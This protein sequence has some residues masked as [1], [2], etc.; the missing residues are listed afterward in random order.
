M[1]VDDIVI[2]W[3]VLIGMNL[4]ESVVSISKMFSVWSWS[5]A[6]KQTK[7]NTEKTHH[8]KRIVRFKYNAHKQHQNYSC[9]V[10]NCNYNII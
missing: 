10:T 6:Y 8:I 1:S 5:S 9:N 2:D 7:D 3:L 4:G